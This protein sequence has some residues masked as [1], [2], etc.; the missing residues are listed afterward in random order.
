MKKQIIALTLSLALVGLLSTVVLA[1]SSD[2]A[3][4]SYEVAAINEIA[5][6]GN[7]GSLVVNAATAGSAPTEVTDATTTY[8]ITT[9]GTSKKITAKID[10][11]MPEGVTLAIN[12]AAPTGG[13]SA[14][15][16]NLTNADQ[17]VVTGISTLNESGK[18][19]TYKL[20]ATAAAGVVAPAQ[21]TVTLTVADGGV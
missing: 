3:T 21:K 2:T 14:G 18:T 20:S 17:D 7:P 1:G 19:I 9:N 13:T 10:T 6:S 12:L 16:V 5:L 11:A 15:D 4:V 8:A